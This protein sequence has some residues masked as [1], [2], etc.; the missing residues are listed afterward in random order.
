VR[1]GAGFRTSYACGEAS[2]NLNLADPILALQVGYAGARASVS[3]RPEA[4]EQWGF[5]VSFRNSDLWLEVNASE[6]KGE[7][8]VE[9][10]T[11]DTALGWILVKARAAFDGTTF[12]S[13][14]TADSQG[15]GVRWV[16]DSNPF[17]ALE[18][19]FYDLAFLREVRVGATVSFSATPGF[20]RL[21][22]IYG[23]DGALEVSLGGTLNTALTFGAFGRVQYTLPLEGRLTAGL[24]FE[25]ADVRLRSNYLLNALLRYGHPSGWLLTLELQTQIFRWNGLTLT[26]SITGWTYIAVEPPTPIVRFAALET[27]LAP[28]VLPSP[29]DARF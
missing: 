9:A 23:P 18:A 17:V 4:T 5:G 24:G 13:S 28:F 16:Y 7:A 8:K 1:F 20:V 21:E 15:F 12:T 27:S 2:L 22:G 19:R 14:G 10:F 6:L 11:A 29:C 26:L 3:Y 25:A